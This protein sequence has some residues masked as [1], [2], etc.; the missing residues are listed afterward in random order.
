MQSRIIG[1]IIVL[2]RLLEP[3]SSLQT[4]AVFTQ[5]LSP[6]HKNVFIKPVFIGD[7]NTLRCFWL[8]YRYNLEYFDKHDRGV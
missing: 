4:F 8:V 3:I 2:S 6:R 1:T 7:K 5:L